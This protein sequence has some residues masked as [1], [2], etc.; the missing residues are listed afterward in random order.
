M[1]NKKIEM[2]F[3]SLYH[4]TQTN[5][6]TATSKTNMNA[7]ID[8]TKK[9][10]TLTP[11]VL[12]YMKNMIDI[13]GK[14][15]LLMK[16]FTKILEL[17]EYDKMTS[18]KVLLAFKMLDDEKWVTHDAEV[19]GILGGILVFLYKECPSKRI[20]GIISDALEDVEEY[21]SIGMFTEKTYMKHCRYLINFAVIHQE[22]QKL[23]ISNVKPISSWVNDGKKTM[24]HL[25]FPIYYDDIYYDDP[26]YWNIKGVEELVV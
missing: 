3:L 19:M 12:C 16:T 18:Q 13:P 2:L 11:L 25:K 20:N 9:S 10:I 5:Q 8:E 1:K 6:T 23:D 14:T 26:Q 22:L 4:F 7:T 17:L 21:K 24:L 15:E